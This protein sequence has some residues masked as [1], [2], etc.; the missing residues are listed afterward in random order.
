VVYFLNVLDGLPVPDLF[1]IG[2]ELA[3]LSQAT[4]NLMIQGGLDQA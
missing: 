3:F 1:A 4:V 2:V